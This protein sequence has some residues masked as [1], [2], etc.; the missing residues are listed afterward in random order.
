MSRTDKGESRRTAVAVAASR[1]LVT[2][3]FA[4]LTHR[5]VAEAAGVPL[6]TT[7]YYFRDRADLT[8]AAVDVVIE[9]E[10]RRR[11]RLDAGDG[12]A[13]E[14]ARAL[15]AVLVP[16]GPGSARTRAAVVYERLTEALRDEELRRIVDG[17]YADVDLHIRR[18]LG[19]S[20]V[21]AEFVRAGVEG[22]LLR[23]LATDEPMRDLVDAVAADLRTVGAAA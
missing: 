21:D 16:P 2:E 18:L 4:A 10:R 5:R 19:A 1:L 23:W 14:V 12:S 15:V 13:A 22:R 9:R 11:A 20:A 17:D 8:R 7:T 6:G 3:G